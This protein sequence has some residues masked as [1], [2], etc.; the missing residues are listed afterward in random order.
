MARSTTTKRPPVRRSPAKSATRST[1]ARPQRPAGWISGA[2]PR[3]LPLAIAPVALGTGAAVAG[4]GGH[5]LWLAWL[6]LAVALLLQI[7]V[8]FANDYSDGVRGTDRFRVGP[9]RLTASGRVKP[10]TV[11]AVALACFLLAAAA[12][13]AIVVLTQVWWLLAVGAAALLAAWFYTGGKRPYGYAGFG[14][15]AVFLFF[16]VAATAG[17][18]FVLI[19][20]VTAEAWFCSVAIGCIACAVLLVNNLRDIE[21]D[22]AA[23]KRTLSVRIGARGSRILYGVLMLVPYLVLGYLTIFYPSASLVFLTVLLSGPAV[24]ITATAKM[25]RELVLALNLTGIA[26]LVYGLGLAAALAF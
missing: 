8:N 19:G 7:G 18:T 6:C 12:G 9:A 16:G 1:A 10:R 14:E 13:V 23:G 26:A 17:T 20:D 25:P 5:H 11:L 15:I 22:R 24:L 3:T 2:R 21:Q 4:G